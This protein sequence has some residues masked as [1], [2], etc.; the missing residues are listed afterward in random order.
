M[1]VKDHFDKAFSCDDEPLSE[2]FISCG[3]NVISYRFE[4][5]V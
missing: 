4:T 5:L 2:Q 1:S 3:E